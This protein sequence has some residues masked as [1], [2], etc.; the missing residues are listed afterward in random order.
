MRVKSNYFMG[1]QREGLSL[2]AALKRPGNAAMLAIVGLG[3]VILALLII[4]TVLVIAGKKELS[5][6]T[7]APL[8]A[9]EQIV[10]ERIATV[11]VVFPKWL[12][13]K[14]EQLTGQMFEIKRVPRDHMPQGVITSFNTIIGKYA[15]KQLSPNE[16]LTLQDVG[17]RVSLRE[18][19]SK[20]PDGSRAIAIQV[21]ETSSVE[22]WVRAGALVDVVWLMSVDGQQ[23]SSVIV[24]NAKVLSAERSLEQDPTQSEQTP[25]TVTLTVSGEDA[26]KIGLA[27]A[28]GRLVLHLRGDEDTLGGNVDVESRRLTLK[29]LLRPEASADEAD[30]KNGTLWLRNS[31][32]K[33]E[34]WVIGGDRAIRREK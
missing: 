25:T 12:I 23:S 15:L 31:S 32:G 22:G 17:D 20:V 30:K 1:G 34:R 9:T 18:I 3:A 13:Q 28:A 19:L 26:Q 2:S 33:V 29:Q 4:S 21:N 5:A 6:A 16:P 24:K 14:D 7:N 10:Q 8:P 27:S 11:Q